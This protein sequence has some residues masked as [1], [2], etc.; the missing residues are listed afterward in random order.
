THSSPVAAA[1]HLG[2]LPR[3]RVPSAAQLLATPWFDQVDG[4]ARGR[5]MLAGIDRRG[6]PV[7]VLG[8]GSLSLAVVRNTA[9]RTLAMASP[10][11]LP[12]LL[13]DTLACV[14]GLMRVGGFLSRGLRSE[15]HT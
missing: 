2:H 3:R 11:Y 9:P 1:I 6:N 12:V 4:K 13:V 8:R 15:E 5:L 10:A 14:S 7:Y